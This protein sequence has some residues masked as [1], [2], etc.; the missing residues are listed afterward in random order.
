MNKKLIYVLI[1]LVVLGVAISIPKIFSKCCDKPVNYN[2]NT[3]FDNWKTYTNPIFNFEIKYPQGWSSSLNIVKASDSNANIVFCPPEFVGE[4]GGCIW[5]PNDGHMPKTDAPILLFQDASDFTTKNPNFKFL[6]L[7]PDNKYSYFLYLT[8]PKYQKE[9][10]QM[11]IS[12][13]FVEWKTY[14]DSQFG[15]QIKYPPHWKLDQNIE[16][17]DK[18]TTIGNDDEKAYVEIS[19]VFVGECKNVPWK[20]VVN[21]EADITK[22]FKGSK[23]TIGIEANTGL[24]E[25]KDT[26][27][28]IISSFRFL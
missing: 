6:A 28:K 3:L 15:Y 9:F 7:S 10:E 27:D 26:I 18:S 12:F 23:N 25:S 16:G 17:L 4:N 5:N 24:P 14:S 21:Y 2:P 11:A 20:V 8:N 1:I 13:K 19:P 22:C